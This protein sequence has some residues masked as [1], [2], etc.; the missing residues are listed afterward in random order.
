MQQYGGPSGKAGIVRY[1]ERMATLLRIKARWSGF[2]GAPGYTVLHFR[3]FGTDGG[4]EG[5]ENPGD[6]EAAANRVRAF[7]NECASVFP[8]SVKITV[9]SEVDVIESTTGDLVDSITVPAMQD[10]VG[11]QAS[12]YSAAI[13]AVVNWRTNGIRNSRRI[14]GRMFLVPLSAVSFGET[15][16][17]TSSARGRIADAAAV[18][19]A[20]SGSPDL[21]V[22]ARPTTKG[23]TDGVVSVV[24]SSS[25][26]SMGAVLRSRRD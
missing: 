17:L 13:G 2:S 19:S 24:T 20:T 8:A 18:L 26:P 10:V 22:F 15:G 6:A 16:E 12:P 5:S 11:M 7:F 14:R 25:V 23:G 3:D 1:P 4:G 9:E 21:V